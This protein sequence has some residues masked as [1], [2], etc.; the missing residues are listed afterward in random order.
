[1]TR[2]LVVIGG[3]IAGLS[4]AQRAQE[5]LDGSGE[6]VEV[7]LLEAREEL[8]GK[9]RTAE[10]GG[11][12]LELGPNAFIKPS[13]ELM[14]LIAKAGVE[15]LSADDSA[16]RRF[17][18]KGG[19]LHELSTHPLKLLKSGVLSTAAKLRALA[20][21]TIGPRRS[22]HGNHPSD[23][24]GDESVEAFFARRFGAKMSA[25]FAGPLVS[26]IYAGDPKR[27]SLTS[28]FPRLNEM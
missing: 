25:T 14:S 9:V 13:P 5:L 17:L 2:R 10:A 20:E 7:L 1:M 27:L 4:C 11:H 12:L 26:G 8:G 19:A 15:L 18:C 28:C 16:K 23:G 22:D 24:W 21:P 6:G 3:G